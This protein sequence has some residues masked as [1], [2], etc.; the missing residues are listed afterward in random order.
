MMGYYDTCVI[1]YYGI[2]VILACANFGCNGGTFFDSGRL[3][4]IM[5]VFEQNLFKFS[6]LSLVY[7]SYEQVAISYGVVTFFDSCRVL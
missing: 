4:W 6:S 5:M 1:G 7:G 2:W 3:I